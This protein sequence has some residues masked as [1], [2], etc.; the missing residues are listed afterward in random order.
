MDF[1][2]PYISPIWRRLSMLKSTPLGCLRSEGPWKPYI[3]FKKKS[4]RMMQDEWHFPQP[5][6]SA[7]AVIY[8]TTPRGTANTRQCNII[9]PSLSRDLLQ[10]QGLSLGQT[11][12]CLSVTHCTIQDNEVCACDWKKKNIYKEIYTLKLEKYIYSLYTHTHTR[13]F[14]WFTETLHRRNGFYTVQTVCAIALHL[15]Y[16]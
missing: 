2:G 6:L 8:N 13:W 12:N 9:P 1:I 10:H 11:T 15:P 7:T 5:L 3:V 4:M 14:L 16:T